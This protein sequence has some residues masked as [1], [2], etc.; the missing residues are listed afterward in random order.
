[1]DFLL[2]SGD[3]RMVRCYFWVFFSFNRSEVLA[4]EA[5]VLPWAGKW[6]TQ[7]SLQAWNRTP[8]GIKI[9]GCSLATARA[10]LS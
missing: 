4:R 3:V 9:L 5:M 7:K 1:M 6:Q 8:Q 10:A 2:S